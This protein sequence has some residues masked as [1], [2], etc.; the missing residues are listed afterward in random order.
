LNA[1]SAD[2]GSAP[3][4]TFT[5]T[6]SSVVALF[7]FASTDAADD[8]LAFEGGSSTNTFWLYN[9]IGTPGTARIASLSS[10][11]CVATT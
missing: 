9:K 5:A 10:A 4:A 6:S 3:V 7:F 8:R 2:A 1:A 11:S